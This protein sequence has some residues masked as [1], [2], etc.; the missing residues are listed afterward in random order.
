MSATIRHWKHMTG[1]EIDAVDRSRA[2]V[3]VTCSPLEV[4]GPHLPTITDNCEGEALTA[5]AAELLAIEHPE[6]VFLQL[7][8]TFVAADLLPHVGSIAYRPST[9]VRVLEDMGRSLCKQ[10]FRNIWV[11]NFHG[12][13]R[14]FVPIEVACDRV[15]R[16]YGGRMISVF[17]LLLDTLTGG[18]TDL[19]HILGHLDGVTPE[20]LTGDAHGGAVETSMMLHL[21]GQHVRPTYRD[22]PQNTVNLAV[23]REGKP[24]LVENDAPPLRELIR[25]FKAKLRYYY[26][27]TYAGKPSVASPELG[28]KMIEVLSQHAADALGEVWRGERKPE[29]CHSPVWRVRWLFMS[30][31][32]SGVFERLVGYESRVI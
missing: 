9:I 14:H 1:Q 10:G 31:V 11:S 2:V 18:G 32:A 26:E 19:A 29:D 22:L 6:I 24:P 13:P 15:N 4:H 20:D 21:L 27:S 7:P 16:R 25:S 5:A 12:G 28:E 23:E 30:R 3:L 8:P 17:S